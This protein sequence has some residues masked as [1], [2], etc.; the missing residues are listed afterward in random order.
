VDGVADSCLI[1]NKFANYFETSCNPFSSARNAEFKTR[2]VEMQSHYD[3]SP[4]NENQMFDVE[5]IS[6]LIND[7]VKRQSGWVGWHIK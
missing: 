3:G 7:M 2:Y 5:V 4:I 6:K 1:A